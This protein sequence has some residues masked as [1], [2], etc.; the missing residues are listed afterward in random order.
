MPSFPHPLLCKINLHHGWLFDRT[1]GWKPHEPKNASEPETLDPV[2]PPIPLHRKFRFRFDLNSYRPANPSVQIGSV[3]CH[4]DKW[5]SSLTGSLNEN[6]AV[7]CFL[8]GMIL[9]CLCGILTQLTLNIISPCYL[10]VKENFHPVRRRAGVNIVA[11]RTS[12]LSNEP[13]LPSSRTPKSVYIF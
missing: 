7:S 9:P 11:D 8:Y 1:D 13:F 3:R 12:V 4:F 5:N 2:S 10:R 6:P